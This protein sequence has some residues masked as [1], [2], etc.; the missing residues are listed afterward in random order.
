MHHPHFLRRNEA[1][2]YL[3]SRYG[4][5]TSRSLAKLAC[6]G[7]GPEYHK[8]GTKMVLYEPSK[9]DEWAR[10]RISAAKRSTSEA[11]A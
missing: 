1:A 8:A 3:R 10:N 11:A 6:V 9:L 7:G 5:G 4:F 2:A